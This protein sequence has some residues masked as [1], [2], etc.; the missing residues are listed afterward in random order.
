MYWI[1]VCYFPLSCIYLFLFLIVNRKACAHEGVCLCLH[2]HPQH[3]LLANDPYASKL[4]DLKILF[5]FHWQMS[6][7]A[8]LLPPS[9]CPKSS[10]L[11]KVLPSCLLPFLTFY[12]LPFF[13]QQV[14]KKFNKLKINKNK[15]FQMILQLLNPKLTS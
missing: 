11:P 6:L 9:P 13:I 1:F 7:I 10:H 3:K 12:F 2:Q 15:N 4:G 14:R 8:P 5:H